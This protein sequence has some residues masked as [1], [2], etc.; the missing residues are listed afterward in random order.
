MD[1][2]RDELGMPWRSYERGQDGDLTLRDYL[3]MDRTILA[4]ERTLL[5]Y[6]R[7]ALALAI[8]GGS[9]IKFFDSVGMEVLGAVFI[10]LGIATMIVGV[11]RFSRIN[12]RIRA[13]IATTQPTAP[14]GSAA[15][16]PAESDD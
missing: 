14:A 2:Q 7:S 12:E 1:E 13:V 16:K 5:A 8:V 3:A 15:A 4:N 11:R 9:A 10:L 6:V